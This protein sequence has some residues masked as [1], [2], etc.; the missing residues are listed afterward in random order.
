MASTAAAI[1]A[2]PVMNITS[3]TARCG[4]RHRSRCNASMQGILTSLSTTS[5]SC[6][7]TAASASLP[8]VT[9]STVC[10]ASDSTWRQNPA[11]A[12]SSSTTKTVIPPPGLSNVYRPNYPLPSNGGAALALE[13]ASLL[14]PSSHPELVATFVP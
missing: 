13:R 12:A 6:P 7:S 3:K 14:G 1:E 5:T 2:N 10:P 9:I 11:T 8:D 4:E